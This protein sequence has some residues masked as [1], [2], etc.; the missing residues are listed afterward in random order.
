MLNFQ[1]DPLFV[2]ATVLLAGLTAGGI[3]KKLR[4][5]SMT[6]QILVGVLIGRAGLGFFDPHM[7]GSLQPITEFAL[8][9]I[10]LT[11]GAHL[12]FRRLRN[13]GRRLLILLLAEIIFVPLF[14]YS[15]IELVSEQHWSIAA[16]MAAISLATAPAT[17][18]ALVQETR[19][20][21]VFVKTLIAA[22]ALNNIACVCLFESVH[23]AVQI[24]L[25]PN[26][27]HTMIDLW[28]R[29]LR[30]LATSGGLG[31]ALGILF[32]S[33]TPLTV[34]WN[35]LS[36]AS[37]I[38]ILLTWGAASALNISP[39]LACM[40]LGVT[41]VN[42]NPRNEHLTG[43]PFEQF[44]P[45]ILAAFF[46]I[47]GMDLDFEYL[48]PAGLL[49]L[50]AVL[51]RFTGKNV[52]TFVAM[53]LAG[54][55]ERVRRFLGLA[56]LPQAGIAI[57]LILIIQQ[58]PTLKEISDLF[59]ALGLTV[60]TISEIIGPIT[61]RAALTWSGET[62]KDRARLIDF[63][64]EENIVTDFYAE[65]KEETITKLTD[66]LIRSNH[67]KVDHDRLLQNIL[68]REKEMS[69]CVGYGLSIPHGTLE[70]GDEIHGVM[71]LSRKGLP[72]QTPDGRPIHC[73]V[74]LATPES[75]RDHH[76]EVLAAIARAVTTNL[77]I[78]HELFN[79]AS[80]AH[81]YELLHAEEAEDFNYFLE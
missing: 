8:G 17:T 74:L 21:G 33:V 36:I 42:I 48:K 7:V 6:G 67:L 65:T 62:G 10:A 18:V 35:R 5:P 54:A 13:A 79:A 47:A 24:S 72:F 61:T 77:T 30:Q 73:V 20:K 34:R 32:N 78:Q 46:T 70:E 28:I 3:A 38:M 44:E 53:T 80:P 63:L 23:A 9:M 15:G 22:V 41:L 16:L 31:I 66:L 4:L 40:F 71:A 50:F 12:H 68:N 19:S 58:D 37:L 57:G 25:D 39:L 29:P 45:A 60:V 59:L 26:A 64:H 2:L 81:A 27:P 55:T 1:P 14:V 52:S 51:G 11:V 69:T 49:A 43:E 56:L 75:Q 76:L